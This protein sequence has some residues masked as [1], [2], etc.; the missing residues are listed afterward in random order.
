MSTMPLEVL[1]IAA[2]DLWRIDAWNL[3]ANQRD[4]PDLSGKLSEEFLVRIGVRRDL[5]VIGQRRDGRRLLGGLELHDHVID[6][7]QIDRAPKRDVE[8][9]TGDRIDEGQREP[10]F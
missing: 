9:L 1:M 10:D 8:H 6:F 5:D 2:G 7:D 4:L 3:G